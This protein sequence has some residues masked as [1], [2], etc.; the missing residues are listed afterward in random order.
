M[1]TAS[2]RKS[3]AKHAI[4]LSLEA[5]CLIPLLHEGSCT[6][7]GHQW[8]DSQKHKLLLQDLF[9]GV[10]GADFMGE[11]AKPDKEAFQKVSL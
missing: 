7:A 8:L 9:E 1:C 6:I 5:H 11:F 3:T 2:M 10:I 4:M